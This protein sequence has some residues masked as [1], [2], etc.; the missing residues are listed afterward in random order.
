MKK[1]L[2]FLDEHFEE[3]MLVILLAVMTASIF[4]QVVMRYV[5]NSAPSWTEEL[6][7]YSF[8]WCAYFGVS[9]G[10]KRNA[11]ISVMAAVDL[12]PKKEQKVMH[13][14]ANLIFLAFAILIFVLGWK[15]TGQIKMLGRKSPAMEIPMWYVYGALPI[16]FLCI[17]FRLLQVLFHQIRTFG[18][19]EEG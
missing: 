1:L 19:E 10:V 9:L 11:H 3:M 17:I 6:C 18:K 16:G 13:V 8:I 15:V 7:R 12:L 5:F 2:H 4:Y 14:V